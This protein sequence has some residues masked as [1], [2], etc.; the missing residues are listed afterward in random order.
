MNKILSALFN[1]CRGFQTGAKSERAVRQELI[2]LA[3]AIPAA[4]TLS[5]LLWVR[6]ALIG[7]LLVV[8]AVEFL[9]TAIETLCD[10]VMPDHHSMIGM[11]KDYGS[12]AVLC[13]LVL[14]SVVWMAAL[15][16]CLSG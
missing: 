1:S 11:A 15:I 2:A 9:N 14:A 16:D 8:L 6:V 5:P 7:V 4:W 3:L 12:A 10:Y 13:T